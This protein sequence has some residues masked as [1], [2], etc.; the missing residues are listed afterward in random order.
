MRLELRT[1]EDVS[2]EKGG[3]GGTA[4]LAAADWWRHWP[5]EPGWHTVCGNTRSCVLEG[6][7]EGWGEVS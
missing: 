2:V 6:G 3:G 7:G 1:G 5:W 4:L